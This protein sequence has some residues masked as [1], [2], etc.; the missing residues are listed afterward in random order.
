MSGNPFARTY[1]SGAARSQRFQRRALRREHARVQK[2][3][4]V[5]RPRLARDLLYD[6]DGALT[7]ER[8]WQR[9]GAHAVAYE[10]PATLL[11]DHLSGSMQR[12]SLKRDDPTVDELLGRASYASSFALSK[13][14]VH[15][16]RNTI[17]DFG[18]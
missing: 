9:V 18:A 12:A 7:D 14:R 1:W 11:S 4:A 15:D 13:D 3:G 17:S 5:R 8:D 2:S 16:R 10:P 6:R